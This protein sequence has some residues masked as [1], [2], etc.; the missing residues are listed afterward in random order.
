MPSALETNEE[1][2]ATEEAIEEV[3]VE[4][5]D[6]EFDLQLRMWQQFMRVAPSSVYRRSRTS[7]STSS[8]SRI[9]PDMQVKQ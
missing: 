5:T 8:D 1:E 3:R 6:S 7:T 4:R 2:V 9:I